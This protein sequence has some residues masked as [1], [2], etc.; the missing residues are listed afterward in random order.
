MPLRAVSS[1]TSCYEF[2][3]IFSPFFGTPPPTRASC[4]P[5]LLAGALRARKA[6]AVNARRRSG[7][8]RE[9]LFPAA[10]FPWFFPAAFPP[11]DAG[12]GRSEGKAAWLRPSCLCGARA[13]HF[14]S[15][16]SGAYSQPGLPSLRGRPY[17]LPKRRL[18][19][20]MTAVQISAVTNI[21]QM[22]T[23]SIAATVRTMT[24]S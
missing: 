6:N 8:A 18:Q 19:M 3:S 24:A 16:L 4:H 14:A 23:L 2:K 1:R 10:L 15:L 21:S 12:E 9:K 5:A 22:G 20:V 11:A 7:K 17:Q 13:F